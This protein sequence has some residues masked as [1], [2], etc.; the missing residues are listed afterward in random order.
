MEQEETRSFFDRPLVE[1]LKP[2]WE[3]A[4]YLGI[5]V[6][7]VVSRFWNLGAYAMSHDESL[8]SLYSFYLYNGTGYQHNP[9]MHGPF[10]F[11]LHALIYFLF[12]DNDY[13][14][15]IGPALA[16]VIAVFTPLLLRRWL[17]RL[18]TLVACIGMLIS[19]II[20]FYSRM[21]WMDMYAV[22]F[23]IVLVACLFHFLHD[24]K[25][26]WLYLGAAV[27]MLNMATK[28]TA[29]IFGFI[30]LVYILIM[31]VWER[32]KL[33]TQLWLL[34]GS[35]AIGIL[36]LTAG[37]IL[38]NTAAQ[39]AVPLEGETSEGGGN[40]LS[41]ASAL[42]IVMGASTVLASLSSILIPSRYP[43][44]SR[45]TDAI[46][47]LP[48]YA[49]VIAVVEMVVI[50][51]LLFT[52]FFTNPSGL[53][54]GVVGS[55]SY[56][57]AQHDV[58]RGGQPWYYYL[59]LMTMY[60]FLPLLISLVAIGYY[61]V[62][63]AVR[64]LRDRPVEAPAVEEV[65][66]D[67][68][69]EAKAPPAVSYAEESVFVGFLAFWTLATLVI[70]SWAGEKMPWLGVHLAQ[71]MILVTGKFVGDLF[72]GVDWR[73]VLRRGGALFA[74]LLPIT[75]FGLY[76]LIRVRPFQGLSIFKLQETGNWLLALGFSLLLLV[77][78]G[79]VA[80]RL[81][82]RYA[83]VV[84]GVT[85]LTVLALFTVRSAWMAA[86]RNRDSATELLVYAHGTPDDPLT[87]NEVADISRRTV[88]DK[89]IEVAYD[90][91]VTWPLEWYMR[92][93]P[94]RKFFGD[95]PSRDKLDTP[96]ILY[97]ERNEGKVKPYL[98]DRYNCFKRRLV[99]WPNQDYFGLTWK[100]VFEILGSP[101]KRKIL[102]DILY[103]RKYPQSADMWYNVHNYRFCVRKD[104]SQQIWN[105][106]AA[107]PAAIES[108]SDPYAEAQVELDAMK[109]WGQ[110]GTSAGQ[111][112][113]PRGVAVGPDGDVYVVDSDNHRVQVFGAAGTFVREWGSHCNVQEGQGCVDP[114]GDGPLALGDGQFQ[115]PWGIAVDS[116][117]LVYVADTWNHRIQVFDA[118]GTFV[119][120]WGTLGQTDA[121]TD[122]MYGPRDIAVDPSGRVLV[123]DTGNKRVL[124]YDAAGNLLDQFGGGGAEPGK[125]EEPVGIDVDSQGNIYVADTWNQR[126]QVF[127]SSFQFLRE[128][129]V[130]AWFGQSV[131]NKPFLAV[132]D[133][134]KV[135][136]TD[137]EGYRVIVF[138]SDGAPQAVFGRYGFESSSFALPTGIDVDDKGYIYVTDTDGQRVI[139]FEP[140]P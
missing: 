72:G 5:L 47:S 133:E 87:M 25:P 23:T 65:A 43:R 108:V 109:T 100:R 75:L 50:Y 132:D 10:L 139:W 98:G 74:L 86:Y 73:A 122:L 103:W 95:Q 52:T 80:W 24:H 130:D 120:T 107:P 40:A 93:Y 115:E 35:L 102:W 64:I 97:S 62:R 94:N 110:V 82:S 3:K 128:W 105:L 13:T 61:W 7:A 117:G 131:V 123:T 66:H 21:V 42:C 12:G 36:L 45:V 78:T 127:D 20:L 59:L 134:D 136:I 67:V 96:I 69:E 14:A 89:L 71:P 51:V 15:R 17:G 38:S 112:N 4:I 46:R 49:W 101:E 8:H 140:L 85:F 77:L 92:E 41:L 22:I 48:W 113:H 63:R 137:P 57:L 44:P 111:F 91:E 33:S 135:Y 129:K 126:I 26:V 104:I 16:G 114:D 76:T 30:G 39:P 32:V 56:W 6:I 53:F 27:L 2:T 70:Y 99:W 31:L 119:R 116:Q 118:Q 18:G 34:L 90:N 106:G 84:A 11:H 9:M 138:S 83:L 121:L 29:Y 125:F 28:E 88:G 79:L 81:K 19:P 58:R 124:V 54:T 55:V 1:L 60:E 68:A 37:V